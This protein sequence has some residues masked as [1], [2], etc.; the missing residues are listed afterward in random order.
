MIDNNDALEFGGAPAIGAALRG[1]NDWLNFCV[2]NRNLW[3]Q[4]ISHPIQS[5]GHRIRSYRRDWED[6]YVDDAMLAA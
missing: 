5:C 2:H 3:A 1:R 6:A 4:F